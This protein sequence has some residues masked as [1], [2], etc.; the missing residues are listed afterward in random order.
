MTVRLE[1]VFLKNVLFYLS[2][3]DDVQSLE[4]VCKKCQIAIISV[5]INPYRLSELYPFNRIINDNIKK[6]DVKD[7][8]LMEIG[9][10]TR[11]NPH[12][13]LEQTWFAEK[14]SKMIV[15]QTTYKYVFKKISIYKNLQIVSLDC[16]LTSEHIDAL[17]ELPLLKKVYVQGQ[18][19]SLEK[20]IE[21]ALQFNKIKFVFLSLDY[22]FGDIEKILCGKNIPQNMTFFDND[23]DSKYFMNTSPVCI[24]V[25]VNKE[26][27]T[28]S[29]QSQWLTSNKTMIEGV[30]KIS[31]LVVEKQVQEAKFVQN[32]RS[33]IKIPYDF[34]MFETL[35]KLTVQYSYGGLVLPKFCVDLSLLNCH[36]D[37]KLGEA[38][39]MHLMLKQSVPT[40]TVDVDQIKTFLSEN[41]STEKCT[42]R[43]D[44][45]KTEGFKI[46]P[47]LDAFEVNCNRGA[48]AKCI[49]CVRLLFED[50]YITKG[51][52]LEKE[53]GV[54]QF[55]DRKSKSYFK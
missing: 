30:D 49:S 1:S 15:T 3:L 7:I 43:F 47:I 41:S 54:I 27:R 37:V 28:Y 11:D 25:I 4:C 24:D 38:K 34:S 33:L 16:I 35:T 48:Q 23:L 12:K 22:C 26:K 8:P 53:N 42:F 19:C 5:Y 13:Y 39:L 2:T 21:K 20:W 52:K 51:G 29:L 50:S 18:Y 46:S 6:T 55:K 31:K 44:G 32:S 36:C 17:C 10:L 9:K 14:V 40:M 45:K